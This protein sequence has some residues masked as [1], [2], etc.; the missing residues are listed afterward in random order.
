MNDLSN[1]E[2]ETVKLDDW[3]LLREA[4]KEIGK[5]KSYIQEL[6]DT[7]KGFKKISRTERLRLRFDATYLEQRRQNHELQRKVHE[8]KMLIDNLIIKTVKL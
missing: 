6:E 8:Q 7:I 1:P 2:H 3:I 4:N 5:L